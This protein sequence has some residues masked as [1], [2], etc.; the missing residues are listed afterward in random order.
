MS[1]TAIRET[2][3][4][5]FTAA[6]RDD[7][8][9]EIQAVSGGIDY[10][11]WLRVYVVE[12]ESRWRDATGIPFEFGFL[13]FASDELISVPYQ[14]TYTDTIVWHGAEVGFGDIQ[15]NNIMVIAVAFNTEL[16]QGYSSPPDNYPFDAYYVD[17]AAA[18]TIDSQWSNT[19][20]PGFTH[21]VFIE[22]GSTTG[23]GYCPR[24]RN[25]LHQV[26]NGYDY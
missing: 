6:P 11:G 20:S 4:A 8:N 10:T 15:S 19:T 14:Q 18:A 26:Y 2:Y 23:C 16:H 24:V 17:A 12:P 13:A 9:S 21:T 5:V 25:A 1:G 7:P 22:E 3:G